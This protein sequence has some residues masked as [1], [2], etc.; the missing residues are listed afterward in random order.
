MSRA[1]AE[2]SGNPNLVH[3]R[4]VCNWEEQRNPSR[5]FLDCSTLCTT[6][7]DLWYSSFNHLV[8]LTFVPNAF[9]GPVIA[10]NFFFLPTGF[11]FIGGTGFV[12]ANLPHPLPLSVSYRW[13]HVFTEE[14]PNTGRLSSLQTLPSFSHLCRISSLPAPLSSSKLLT[15]GTFEDS[16]LVSVRGFYGNNYLRMNTLLGLKVSINVFLGFILFCWGFS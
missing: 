4:K 12:L 7:K 16:S 14:W 15:Y 11:L 1:G 3:L 5:R 10:T 6:S 13:K 9:Q 2:D 8:L